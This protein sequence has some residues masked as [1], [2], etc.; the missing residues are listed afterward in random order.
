MKKT[1]LLISIV[2][3]SSAAW[4][5]LQISV[6][7]GRSGI[8]SNSVIDIKHDSS[9]VWLGTGGGVSVTED[10][11]AS[12][13]TYGTETL[14]SDEV[15]AMD[16]NQRG[17]WV[18][19]SHSETVQ[20]ESYPYGNGISL[21]RDGGQ[22]WQT[23]NP[24]QSSYF[25]KLSYDIST[26]DSIAYAA[27]FY[28]GLIRTLDCGATWQ[29]L[30]PTQLDSIN[31][32]SL[33]YAHGTYTS[34]GNRFFSVK[35]DTTAFPDTLSVWG[36]DADGIHRFFF[37]KYF[38]D[39]FSNGLK[40]WRKFGAPLPVT[41]DS[42]FGRT[43]ILDNMGDTTCNSGVVSKRLFGGQDGFFI[44]SDVYLDITDSSGCWVEAGMALPRDAHH[45]WSSDCSDSTIN[46]YGLYFSI[47]YVGDLCSDPQIPPQARYHAWFNARYLDENNSLVVFDS[48]SGSNADSFLNNWSTIKIDIDSNRMVKFLAI[49]GVDT[50]LVWAPTVRLSPSMMTGRNI[51]LGFRSSGYAGKAY[52]DSVFANQYGHPFYSDYPDSIAHY[53]FSSTDSTIADSLKLPGNHVVALGIN[54]RG[55]VKSAWAACRPVDL[56]QALAVAYTVDD[57]ATW[58]TAPITGPSGDISVEAWDF[59]FSGD[60]VYVATSF[61]LYRST[62]DYSRWTMLSGF[63]DLQ[64]QTFYQDSAPFYAVDVVNGTL[65]A[66]GSDGTIRS[67]VG[68]GWQVFRSQLDPDDYYAYPSPFSPT[69][70][71]RRGTTIHFKPASDTRVSVKIYDFNLDLVKT[72]ATD[73]PRRGGVESDD[74]V[75]DGT[76]GDGKIVAN[77]VYFFRIEFDNGKDLWGKV[78]MI[79]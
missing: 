24:E 56:G 26:Y 35:T 10:N 42:A 11:G 48:Y 23:F 34:Y 38:S 17:A 64:N 70:S 9:S 58:H 3:I 14:P 43:G 33:D 39:N 57:G 22:T 77:G 63:K 78:V 79:K 16:V 47:A 2:L 46:T 75:W 41:V 67:L 74:I 5:G 54:K 60:T 55:S 1:I 28:G 53:F 73:L 45:D 13:T 6:E 68:G 15:S 31:T 44:Q 19:T 59:A 40:K 62:G 8:T 51:V 49:S 27:C 72:V 18:G 12:W 76:N 25:G 66:G 71:T 61:G 37:T 36:G 65:W 30:Y 50:H 29:N 20:D 69:A 52:H 21:T 32:D 7:G 4:A